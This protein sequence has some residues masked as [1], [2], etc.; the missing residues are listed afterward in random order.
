MANLHSRIKRN[1]IRLGLSQKDLA[2]KCGVSQPTVA[3]WERGGHIPRQ[4]ALKKIAENLGVDSV[5]LLSG[6]LPSHQTPAYQHLNTPIRHA[7]VYNWENKPSRLLKAKPV[8]YISIATESDDIF[9]LIAPEDMGLGVTFSRGTILV[10]DRKAS[11]AA[12]TRFL[13]RNG[14]RVQLSHASEINGTKL[15]PIAR[16]IYSIKSH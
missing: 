4:D 10:F 8:R 11:L 12:N 5:W 1:R 14:K 2:H 9:G 16:L 6:E 7:P 3:N 15:D 13:V